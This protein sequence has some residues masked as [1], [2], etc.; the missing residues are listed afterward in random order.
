MAN[1]ETI[2]ENPS[3]GSALNVFGQALFNAPGIQ[4]WYNEWIAP[5]PTRQVNGIPTRLTFGLEEVWQ[6]TATR[7]PLVGPSDFKVIGRYYA[8]ESCIIRS[9]ERRV[10]KE[11]RSRW[12]P[13]H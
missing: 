3:S 11:C 5:D 13:Y 12:S 1:T 8:Y 9:E 2:S 6:N 4:A 7:Q 10:G